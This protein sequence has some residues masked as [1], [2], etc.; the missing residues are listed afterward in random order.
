MDLQS[1]GLD[2]QVLTSCSDR[3]GSKAFALVPEAAQS[4]SLIRC[5]FSPSCQATAAGQT[6]EERRE[7]QAESEKNRR[8]TTRRQP[9]QWQSETRPTPRAD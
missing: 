9:A 3:R 5:S 2:E 8:H 7:E 1:S 4:A 6:G